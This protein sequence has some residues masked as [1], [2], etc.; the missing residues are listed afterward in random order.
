LE[1]YGD[2]IGV[3]RLTRCA[4]GCIPQITRG[5]SLVVKEDENTR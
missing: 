3:V 1:K 2:L 4:R 5:M